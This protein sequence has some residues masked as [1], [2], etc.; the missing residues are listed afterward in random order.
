VELA[1]DDD[2]RLAILDGQRTRR[3]WNLSTKL[4]PAQVLALRKIATMKSI[5]NQTLIHQW[6]AQGIHNELRLG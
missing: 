4:D 5:P 1:P 6:L 2:L 3:L